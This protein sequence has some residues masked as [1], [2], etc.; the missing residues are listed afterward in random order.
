MITDEIQL[1]VSRAL[2][3]TA[4][5]NDWKLPEK[6][7]IAIERP[8]N[9]KFGDW[10]SNLAL[11]L[12]S[13]LNLPARDIA[14]EIKSSLDDHPYI[15]KTDIAGPGF[16][17]I[18]LKSTWYQHLISLVLKASEKYGK[19]KVNKGNINIEFVSA[20]PVGPLHIGHGRWAAVGDTLANILEATGYK[21]T[22]EFYINDYGRQTN[23]FAESVI[24][25]ANQQLGKEANW[26]EDGY[27]GN[28][29]TTVSGTLIDEYGPSIV[30]N[31]EVIKI[32][33]LGKAL[34]D[35]KNT[36]ENFGVHFDVWFSETKL[37]QSNEIQEAIKTLELNGFVYKKDEALWFKSQSLGDEKDRVV[38]R[39]NG[40]PTYFAS[41]I[42]YHADKL[43]RG[44]EKLIN[45]WGA[46]HH[47]YINRIKA[48]IKAL[49]YKN[50]VLEVLLGQLVRLVKSGKPVKMSKR[51][52]EYITFDE[53]L[54]EIGRD[55]VRYTFLTQSIDSN[56]DFDLDLVKER[57]AKNPVFYVQYAYARI[58][59]VFRFAEEQG[60]KYKTDLKYKAEK[61]NHQTEI[62]L[63]KEISR[64][65]EVIQKSADNR[66]PHLLTIYAAEL[67][68]AFHLFY[69][70][71]RII[72]EDK[73][74]SISRLHLVECT[75]ITLKN[76]LSLLSVSAPEK[77]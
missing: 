44:F 59:N 42:A 11:A 46:D 38:I 40:E 18:Y 45:I 55:A 4:Q 61:L 6:F 76:L 32:N 28:Y 12:S 27:K 50:E 20:N 51:S 26:P 34:A 62:K 56:L 13:Q 9:E 37:H 54:D 3:T 25:S 2:K 39:S 30:E 52:G 31:F 36:L 66:T 35:I 68:T 57:S 16:L 5:K 10:S 71:C 17:N 65:E 75:R 69:T 48:S 21:V 15:E 58:C 74:L 41:D 19:T 53:L 7:S 49:G 24:A 67:A 8:R 64:F 23:L 72:T 29:V 70:K 77:M 47:G 60:I 63:L 33:S 22:R 43:K 1:L 73:D 14:A